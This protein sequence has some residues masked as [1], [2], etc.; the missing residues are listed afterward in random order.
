[1]SSSALFLLGAGTSHG[2]GISGIKEMTKTFFEN[3]GYLIQDYYERGKWPNNIKNPSEGV[4]AI[5][6]LKKIIENNYQSINIELLLEALINLEK[7]DHILFSI[8]TYPD[9]VKKYNMFYG[10]LKNILIKFIRDECEN[11]STVNYLYPLTT[12]EYNEDALD[13]FTLN[14]DGTIEKMC[15]ENDIIFSD[16]FKEDWNHKY[17][18]EKNLKIRLYKLHGS[19]YWFKT[20][21][22]KYIKLPIKKIDVENLLYFMDE[23]ISETVIWPMLTKDVSTGPFPWLL[24]KFRQKLKTSDLCF[25]MGYSFGDEYI[26]RIIL[27]Q[28][29]INSNLWLLILDHNANTL[30]SILCKNNDDLKHR[31]LTMTMDI[32][33]A[34]LSRILIDKR[35]W[36]ERVRKNEED[37]MKIV[38]TS[39]KLVISNWIEI[40]QQYRSIPHYDRIKYLIKYLLHNFEGEEYEVP[41]LQWII[42]DLTLRFGIEYYLESNFEASLYWFKIFKECSYVLDWIFGR[43][44]DE[45][46]QLINSKQIPYWAKK[47]DP[48]AYASHFR[49]FSNM[50]ESIGYCI[51]LTDKD[52]EV[53][54]IIT[55]LFNSLQMYGPINGNE[56]IRQEKII[57]MRKKGLVWSR[58]SDLL[59][60]KVKEKLKS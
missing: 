2:A 19:L 11:I 32:E 29:Q 38:L 35:K 6:L 55:N 40:F 17:F 42:F 37:T 18:E 24:E 49:D 59:I 52:K 54:S 22:G 30:K 15:M 4:D 31:I 48:T 1:M 23:K 36:I 10:V 25:I 12:F 58:I 46:Y 53:Q 28:M 13:I 3:I 16:G 43:S 9:E 39:Q 57:D 41:S 26:K 45:E 44:L 14:Y 51:K 56:D 50:F 5:F 7:E 33:K 60:K 20:E 8:L 27:D 34:L 47:K 21:T